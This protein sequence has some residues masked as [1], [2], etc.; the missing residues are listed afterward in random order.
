MVSAFH[1]KL[2]PV[3]SMTRL[4]WLFALS[5][6]STLTLNKLQALTHDKEKNHL[7]AEQA[8]DILQKRSQLVQ[9]DVQSAIDPRT[10]EK[11]SY[12]KW[13]EFSRRFDPGKKS[14]FHM[15]LDV[16][17]YLKTTELALVR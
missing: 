16:V 7:T 11:V 17:K 10:D 2:N 13:I 14:L 15:M 9:N 4:A 12:L 5:V 1:S 8:N 3:S 6:F